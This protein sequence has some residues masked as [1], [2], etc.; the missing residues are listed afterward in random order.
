MTGDIKVSVG[1]DLHKK[2]ILGTVLW[3]TGEMIQERFDR[4]KEGLFSLK[5]WATG[6]HA[7]VVACE[8]TSDYWV[9]IYDL[10]NGT[11]PVLVGNAHD[12]KVLSHKKTDKIDSLMIAR[13]ALHGMIQ[14]SRVFAQKH[15]EFRKLVRL[16][17]G[18]VQK[19]TDIKNQIH[20]ILDSELL[21]LSSVMSDIF[22]AT[23]MHLLQG[24]VD[25]TPLEV[26]VQ[27]LPPRIRKREGEIRSVLSDTLSP[28][29]LFR[30]DCCLR[31]IRCLDEQIEVITESA[32]AYAYENHARQVEILLSVPGIGKV[33]ALTLI[34]E[35][36]DVSDF[37]SAEKLASWVGVVP[38]VAQSAGKL[39]TGSITKR[40]SAHVRWILTEI[41]HATARSRMNG[42]K[43]FFARKKKAL[44]TGK[45]IIALARKIISLV[46][47]LLSNDELYSDPQFPPKQNPNFV[48]V[49]VPKSLTLDELLQ[50][51]V[52]ANV[53]L[54]KKDP[55]IF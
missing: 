37:S 38:T 44:G 17:H 8:S 5:A 13:L 54:K 40:G 43:T 3:Q 30:L 49:K 36:G 21:Q 24:L 35:I 55:E 32:T 48:S 19:R 47:H 10:L 42:L 20:H 39:H 9:Q 34:A 15:R 4:T 51:L 31:L 26:L 22:G 16:R 27:K 53:Y 2:F 7:D 41:A 6:H 12:I 29:A 23:G 11:I 18:L 1:L 52:E 28:D 50:I 45:A 14:P 46:W 33:G 25:G